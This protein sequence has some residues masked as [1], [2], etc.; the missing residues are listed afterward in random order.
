MRTELPRWNGKHRGA[1]ARGFTLIELLVVVAIIGLLI[2]ILVPSLSAARQRAKGVRCLTNLRTLGQGASIYLNENNDV[3][4]PGRLPK[5]D[6]CNAFARIYGRIKYRPTFLAMMSS[7]V[8]APPFSDPMACA[9]D[10]DMFGEDGDR[11]NYDYGVYVCPSRPEWTD[12]RNGSYGYNYQFLGNSRLLNED[13]VQSYKNWPVPFSRIKHPGN[14]VMAGDCM[15]T[16]AAFAPADRWEYE[17]DS[18][19]AQRYGNEGFNLDPPRVDP[20]NGEM[21]GSKHS[22][23]E[24]SAVDPRHSGRGNV[25][26]VDGHAGAFTLEELGYV[27]NP[28]QTIGYEGLNHRWTPD[29][30]DVPWTPDYVPFASP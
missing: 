24:R 13:D 10:V 6:D 14:M 23:P 20:V 26:W 8:G 11:Q 2:S 27:F 1:A 22:P 21:A 25:V 16:A 19:D 17:D 7:S 4:M 5:I 29:G 15:G 12:E 28:D 18:R 9:D 30:R 3:L